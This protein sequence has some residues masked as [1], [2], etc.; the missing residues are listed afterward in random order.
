M[1]VAA[2]K[3]LHT[4]GLF[5]FITAI[6][7]SPHA[8]A[9]P[10]DLDVGFNATGI[11]STTFTSGSAKAHAV[12]LQP[13]GEIIVAG[14]YCGVSSQNCD[15][16]IERLNTN[17]S[18]DK[19]FNSVNSNGIVTTDYTSD[20][21]YA[22]AVALTSAGRIVAAG[23]TCPIASGPCAFLLVRYLS[24]GDY[25]LTLNNS[26]TVTT[27]FGANDA[28]AYALALQPDGKVVL[29][30]YSYNGSNDDF[31]LT[32]Y[33]TDGSLDYGFGVGGIVT[34]DFGANDDRINAIALLPDGRVVAA[35]QSCAAGST[36]CDFALARYN[37]DGRLDLSLNGT[38]MV[39]TPIGSGDDEAYGLALQPD[40]KAILAGRSCNLSVTRCVFAL[41]RYNADGTLDTAFNPTGAPAGTVT[42]AVGSTV[43]IAASVALQPDGK[44]LAAGYYN[45][46]LNY[47]YALV[48][49]TA[50]GVRD[51]GFGSGGTVTTDIANGGDY[52]NAVMLQPDGKIVAAGESNTQTSGDVSVARYFAADA[53]WDVTPDPF[54]FSDT[55]NVDT[56]SLQTSNLITISGL[57]ADNIEVPVMV[58]SGTY[59]KIGSTDYT[60]DLGWAKNGDQFNVQQT[61]SSTPG[62][63]TTMG[64][65]VGGIVP[66]TNTTVF[67]GTTTSATF[68]STTK[69]G[70]TTGGGAI[71][72]LSG[73]VLAAMFFARRFQRRRGVGPV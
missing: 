73:A 65:I 31:T 22:R 48:R 68:S 14:E 26:G 3:F 6:L 54:G 43:G 2:E 1:H 24:N 71:G 46:G 30:G 57:G 15:F 12:A 56:G 5:S 47:D 72:L 7:I 52:A 37:T 11:V 45:N 62:Q 64:L 70:A 51:L 25:D 13:N 59:A 34:T 55:S 28:R 27:S 66:A 42:T 21:D 19:N 50:N 38:G 44:I 61:A 39:T 35:G 20:N 4:C 60:A 53:P 49:Y 36:S 29:G 17:G 58:L 8:R 16:L 40:A 69:Q 23:Y 18:L 9:A 32:R 67:L 63:M 33:N 41:A 10:G